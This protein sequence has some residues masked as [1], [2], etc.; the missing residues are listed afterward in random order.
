M[1]DI[2][3]RCQQRP[4]TLNWVADGG[5]MAYVHGMTQRWCERCAVSEQLVYATKIAATIPNLKERLR[6]LMVAAEVRDL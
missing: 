6:Q 5:V 2:C 3:Q 4:A 1:T